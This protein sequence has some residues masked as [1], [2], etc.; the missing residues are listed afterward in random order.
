MFRSTA[1]CCPSLAE[2]VKELARSATDWPPRLIP[3]KGHSRLRCFS[4]DDRHHNGMA[5]DVSLRAASGARHGFDPR[6]QRIGKV[7]RDTSTTTV[8]NASLPACPLDVS[9]HRAAAKA[10]RT[11]PP[12]KL[13]F[14]R[15]ELDFPFHYLARD[16]V[17]RADTQDL[18][19]LLRNSRLALAGDRSLQF[20]HSYLS[21]DMVIPCQAESVSLSAAAGRRRAC[22][23]DGGVPAALSS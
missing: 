19:T 9:R 17:M 15:R 13:R 8:K 1:P 21:V 11:N 6:L 10:D 3:G 7:E 18:A 12:E 14:S 16:I 22:R 5:Y 2:T 23:R 20:R 4:D